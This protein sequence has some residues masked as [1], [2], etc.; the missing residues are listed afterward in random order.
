MRSTFY[1]SILF[2]LIAQ[3]GFAQNR[4]GIM[5]QINISF[6]L[7][8]AWKVNSKL[9]NRQILYQNPYD[10][11]GGR[12]E[13]ERTDLDLIITRNKGAL[14]GLGAGYLIRRYDADG[15]SYLHRF[16]Q[17]YSF[18]RQLTGWS[19]AHRFRTDQSLRN[20]EATQYR[21]RYRIGLEKP[22]NGLEVD[23]QEFYLKFTNEYIGIL[24]DQI[25]NMEIRAATSVGYNLTDNTQF[26]SGLDY[27][28]ENLVKSDTEH[29]LWLTIGFYHSF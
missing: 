28:A 23:P 29:L 26:E 15:G 5:P 17:Q 25:G 7:G 19:L 21:L 24:K 4:F 2:I 18:S 12:A 27:R 20:D 9:E 6:K 8:E 13:F 16:I 10:G 22:L 3:A 11:V 1:L 14:K